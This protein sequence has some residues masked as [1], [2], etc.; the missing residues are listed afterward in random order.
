MVNK[1]KRDIV[2]GWVFDSRASNYQVISLKFRERKKYFFYLI[3]FQEK[4]VPHKPVT[5]GVVG[6]VQNFSSRQGDIYI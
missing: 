5:G 1:A 4:C 3:L 6:T 2:R